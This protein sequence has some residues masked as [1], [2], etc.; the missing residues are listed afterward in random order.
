[1]NDESKEQQN[2]EPENKEPETKEPETKEPETKEPETKETENKENKEQETKNVEDNKEDENN[3]KNKEEETNQ[4]SSSNTGTSTSLTD[5]VD[6]KSITFELEIY[7]EDL[8]REKMLLLCKIPGNN[9]CVECSEPDPQWASISLGIFLCISCSGIHRN[10]GVHIS[11]VRSLFLDNWKREELE[12]IRDGGNIK[13]KSSWE[14]NIPQFFIRPSPTDST[15]LKEQF[16]RSKYERKEYMGESKTEP[17]SLTYVKE[18][19]L[20]KKGSVVKNWKRRWFVLYGTIL[21]YYKKQKDPFPAG[22]ILLKEATSIDCLSDPIDNK[23]YC[24]VIHTPNRDFFITAESGKEM[25]DWVQALK[26]AKFNY[27]S[28]KPTGKKATDFDVKEVIPK[29]SNEISIQKRK[30]NSKTFPNCFIGSSAVDWM[31]EKLN[32]QSRNEAVELGKK[33]LSDE[34]I[35]SVSADSFKDD[36][37]FYQFLK[38]Q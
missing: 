9:T 38:T 24:F 36:Y 27:C 29:L 37:T 15:A 4:Q 18:G 22:V 6:P 10:L 26:V 32:I 5:V 19:F 3:K 1:M 34:Y 17:F 7:K 35:Q 11:R 13:S 33:L 12:F 23:A 25:F 2:K 14:C 28:D 16:I 8:L 21:S 20:T 30:L 31:I